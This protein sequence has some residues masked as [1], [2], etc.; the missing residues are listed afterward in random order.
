M[1][2]L[3]N[4]TNHQ[5]IIKSADADYCVIGT[6]TYKHSIIIPFETDVV[7]CNITS[8]TELN[9]IMVQQLC[10]YQPEVI[11]LA[12]GSKII[13]P[14]TDLLEPLVKQN[15]GLEVLHNQA[16]ART[17]NVLMA[18]DRKAVCLMLIDVA[19]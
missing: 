2:L 7:S 6:H 19:K 11:I 13:F 10:E 4:R 8:V 18:E 1:D 15:I 14:A 5:N 9:Q 16:A 17:F 12:T 3:E